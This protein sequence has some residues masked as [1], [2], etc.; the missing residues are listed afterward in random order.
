MDSAVPYVVTNICALF[1]VAYLASS[2]NSNRGQS[3]NVD[4][5][6]KNRLRQDTDAKPLN[7]TTITSQVASAKIGKGT[8][9]FNIGRTA[10]SNQQTSNEEGREEGREEGGGEEDGG[11]ED[12]AVVLEESNAEINDDMSFNSI[13]NALRTLP[14][15]WPENYAD[16]P[17][18]TRDQQIKK[19]V[20]E[21]KDALKFVR[22]RHFKPVL[23]QLKSM[24]LPTPIPKQLRTNAINQVICIFFF[25]W[26]AAIS[27][28]LVG[29]EET[30]DLET[31]SADLKASTPDTQSRI[32]PMITTIHGLQQ[33][34]NLLETDQRNISTNC[35]IMKT[36]DDSDLPVP[37]NLL[38]LVTEWVVDLVDHSNRLVEID[39]AFVNS[40]G[41]DD[42]LNLDAEGQAS[43]FFYKFCVIPGSIATPTTLI[44]YR[45]SFVLETSSILDSIG[46]IALEPT[47]NAGLKAWLV[48]QNMTQ[49][50]TVSETSFPSVFSSNLIRSLLYCWLST[51]QK[52]KLHWTVMKIKQ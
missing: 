18:G 49:Y 45:G 21:T 47:S 43:S 6:A 48:Q 29:V 33:G 16:V 51:T 30:D 27:W 9:N 42:I 35:N 24:L 26:C 4:E 5:I 38:Q 40:Y 52:K 13:M 44:E 1:F 41:G 36:I 20:K 32:G 34:Q 37:D 31:A 22:L 12:T 14:P 3:S 50:F 23:D 15:N 8:T 25:D 2:R 19:W 11:E 7:N 10:D 17:L 28:I 39:N 46:K